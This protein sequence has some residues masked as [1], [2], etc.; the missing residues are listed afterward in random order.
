[1]I[2]KKEL[3]LDLG[4]GIS[5]RDGYLGVDSL[6]LSGVDITHNLDIFPY[7]FQ[8]SE[9]DEI[10]L[11]NV[12]EHLEHPIKVM[13]EI[14]RISKNKAKITVAVPYFRSFYATIDPTHKHFFG[15][16]WFNYFDPTHPF[17]QKYCY[18]SAEFKV[19]K[20]EFNRESV[21]TRKG[22]RGL[23]R[24]LLVWYA[25]KSPDRYESRLSHLLPLSSLTFY[26]EVIKK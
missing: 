4:C 18:T 23:I 21:N 2:E 16:N 3:K 15:I 17:F 19:K 8:D 25:N 5:K 14:Y 22:L 20:I 26:L 9:V 12:L 6:S 1:M 13:E 10:W 11:D 7:P 24:K